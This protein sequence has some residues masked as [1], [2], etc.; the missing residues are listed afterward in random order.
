MM[1]SSTLTPAKALAERNRAHFP[2]EDAAYRRARNALLAEEIELRRHIERVAEM[3]RQLPPGGEVKQTYQF[4]GENGPVTLAHLFGDK[5]TLVVYSYM[6]GPQRE[7]PCPMC[8]SLM[9]SWEGKVPDIEQRVALAMVARSPIGRLKAAKA[10]RG[11]TQLKVYADTDGAFTRD[12]VSADDADMPGYTVFTRRDGKIRHFYS[13][14]MSGAMADP[15]Q[16]PRGAPDL[17][18]L[19][20]LLDTTPEGRGANWYP[21]LQYD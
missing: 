15:G 5:D 16:D 2:N 17:D 11:W 14:E 6:F 20:T 21:K 4:T 7:R 13:G 1:Q 19:W 9:A 3:R 18:P 8:T 10:A 12:Y